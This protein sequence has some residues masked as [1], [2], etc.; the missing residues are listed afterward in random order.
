MLRYRERGAITFGV[1]PCLEMLVEA[2]RKT[3]IGR[4]LVLA[5]AS[6]LPFR[7]RNR[8]PHDMLIRA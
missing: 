3:G 5:E 4:G 7:K 2:Q 1:D 6:H 8:R